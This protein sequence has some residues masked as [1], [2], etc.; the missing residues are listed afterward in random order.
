M[1]LDE[2][3]EGFAETRDQLHQLA[4]FAVSSARHKAVGRM[5]LK[6]TPG[7]FGT[8]D[9]DGKVARVEADLL[10]FENSGLVAAQTITTIRAASE[11]FG[12]EYESEWFLDFHDPLAPADPD[13]QLVIN[14]EAVESIGSWFK[15]GFAVLNELRGHGVD[16]DDVSE[17]QLWPEHFDPATELGDYDRGQRAGFGAS[18]G[19]AAHPEPYLYVASWSEID[20]TNTYWNNES[21]NGSSM[22]HSELLSA[23]DPATSA[24]DFY[25]R[26]YEILHSD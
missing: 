25:L 1:R 10:V 22:S 4:F 18:P 9:F 8:P 26:G 16:G 5:G 15:F 2:I 6:D 19:D 14:T 23:H 20:R 11:F 3:P 7:G 21:F 24:L 17:V 12:N 13:T